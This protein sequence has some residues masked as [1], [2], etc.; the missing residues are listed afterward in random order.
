MTP[1]AF[2]FKGVTKRFGD[3]IANE[4]VSF[5]VAPCAIH[6][7]VGEN[8]AG[9][10][11]I[12]KCLYGM[13][14]PESGEIWL[15]GAPV[16]LS[17]PQK[18]IEHG[19]GMVHQHFMLVPTL[20]VWENIVL[21]NEPGFRLKRARVAETLN[22]L[23]RRFGFS[24][25]LEAC[26]EDLSVGEQ[27]QVEIL[28]LLYRDAQILIF[29]EPTAVLTPQEVDRLFLQF[30]ELVAAGKT[31]VLISHKLKEV[32]SITQ[33]LTVMRR[34]RVVETRQTTGLDESELAAR[35]VGRCPAALPSERHP[36]GDVTLEVRNLTVAD[37]HR[38]LLENISLSVRA[39]EIVGVAGVTG[40]GQQELVE[41]LTRVRR[42]QSGTVSI[43]G[44]DLLRQSVYA[45]KQKGVSIIPPDRLK[46]G[47]VANFS[48]E[49][50]LV[51]GHHREKEITHGPLLSRSAIR[52]LAQSRI[53]EYN[54]RPTDPTTAIG[55]LSGGNQQKVI[56][57]REA[58]RPVRLL[59]AAYPTRGVDIG[60][61]E[62]IHTLF[63]KLRN[64][65]AAIL[66]IST[67]LDEL[68][69]LSD[70]ILVLYNGR[71]TGEVPRAQANERLIGS[72]MTGAHA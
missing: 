1:P 35:I 56:T 31:I 17:S 70:R 40:N 62:F 53:A 63:L 61:I 45:T 23:Q 37:R 55:V 71:C 54:V 42:P 11:T 13:Y 10:S 59:I 4:N 39:G 46:E 32:L 3:L 14:Q 5:A 21:G 51:L 20:A 27:Q 44:E 38:T 47:L 66:L 41:V 60:A 49:E 58:G 36:S 65:G 7:V 2:E 30:K 25:N 67:E 68:L 15:H 33:T 48:V 16:K 12:M 26:V 43:K 52:A 64:E 57:A 6:G 72:W 18:A 28:K 9:K 34:G 8:G 29:D 69:A 24:L 22:Q 19:I 50:N